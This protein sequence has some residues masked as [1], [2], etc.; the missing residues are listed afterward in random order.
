MGLEFKV[1][2]TQAFND[3]CTCKY[4]TFNRNVQPPTDKLA[5]IFFVLMASK[6]LKLDL[7][8]K[9]GWVLKSS[10]NS[11]LNGHWDYPF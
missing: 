7:Q 10:D 3:W 5:P 4:Y 2:G 9:V 6:A 8:I 1:F 11:L